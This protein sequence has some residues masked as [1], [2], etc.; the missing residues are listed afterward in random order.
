MS[1]S[2]KLRERTFEI[3]TFIDVEDR[4]DLIIVSINDEHFV[5]LS[6]DKLTVWVWNPA[7]ACV[8]FAYVDLELQLHLAETNDRAYWRM[9]VLT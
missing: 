6:E 3:S 8:R 2:F 4:N 1:L 9:G 5:F 7:W